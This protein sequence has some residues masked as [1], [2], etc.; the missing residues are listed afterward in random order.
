MANIVAMRFE[1][2][3]I[4]REKINLFLSLSLVLAFRIISIE[5]NVIGFRGSI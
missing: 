2:R 5:K 3:G 1:E 4:T